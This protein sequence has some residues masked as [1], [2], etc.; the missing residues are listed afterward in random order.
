MKDHQTYTKMNQ[1]DTDYSDINTS[2]FDQFGGN[3]NSIK[4]IALSNVSG[5]KHLRNEMQEI[6]DEFKDLGL[7]E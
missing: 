5:I 2:K 4:S 7:N 3:R 6:N 1:S